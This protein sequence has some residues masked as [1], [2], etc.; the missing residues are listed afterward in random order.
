M[1]LVKVGRG[2]LK[3]RK[4]DGYDVPTTRPT[5][6]RVKESLFASI[7]NDTLN[8]V[9]LDLFCGTGSLGI[10]SI[11]MGAKECY[12]ADNN[13]EIINFLN[14]NISHLEIKN[15][16]HVLHEDYRKSLKY[17][18][19]N[20]I[21]FNIVLVDAPYKMMV[22]EE[23]INIINEYNLLYDNGIVVIEYSLDKLLDKYDS[24][25]LIKKK[26][27]GDKFINIYRYNN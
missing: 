15:K 14:K 27:Y 11:S 22:S 19:D 13:R 16:C 9:V 8:A 3:G 10:E 17:F 6:D 21:K 4:I 20:D 1:Y 24:L 25:C 23:V 7:Q 12:F 2:Y 5:M 18:R 26:K